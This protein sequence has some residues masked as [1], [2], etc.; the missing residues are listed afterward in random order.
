MRSLPPPRIT[1]KR[2]WKRIKRAT[3]YFLKHGRFS[4][5]ESHAYKK[6]SQSISKIKQLRI[7]SRLRKSK[8]N[9]TGV[10]R[11]SGNMGL[12]TASAVTR[13]ASMPFLS[14]TSLVDLKVKF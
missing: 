12:K 1:R 14:R 10:M 13:M 4:D 7:S 5:P 3:K 11:A 2:I 9:S 6:K 8:C